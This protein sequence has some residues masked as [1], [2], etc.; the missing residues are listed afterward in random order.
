MYSLLHVSATSNRHQA[1]ISVQ[2]HDMF[3]VT[4]WSPCCL[5]LLCTFSHI[6]MIKLLNIVI[7]ILTNVLSEIIYEPIMVV[8]SVKI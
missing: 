7:H 4:V 6:E 3:S 8:L 5:H 1:D 2:G